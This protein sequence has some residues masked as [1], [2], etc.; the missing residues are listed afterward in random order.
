[1]SQS[2]IDNNIRT[3]LVQAMTQLDKAEVVL[4]HVLSDVAPGL[5]ITK[6]I[7]FPNLKTHEVQQAIT[8][9]SHWTQVSLLLTVLQ[10]Y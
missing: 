1:M 10:C 6:T 9:D 8:E 4:S 3:K 2:D 7:I 5:R